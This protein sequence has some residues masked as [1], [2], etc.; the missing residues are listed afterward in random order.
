M[1][2][3]N[4]LL[5]VVSVLVGLSVAEAGQVKNIERATL[6]A[7]SCD[8]IP[9]AEPA[10]NGNIIYQRPSYLDQND[11]LH[12]FP[13]MR[14]ELMFSKRTHGTKACEELRNILDNHERVDLFFTVDESTGNE[15]LRDYVR[16]NIPQPP[17]A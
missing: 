11:D 5:S 16:H 7:V 10:Y 3:L 2:K 15:Q 1:K 8:Y 17:G 4:V 12:Q 14:M 13:P 6:V 9:G